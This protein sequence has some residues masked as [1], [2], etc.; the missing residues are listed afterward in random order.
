LVSSPSI[1]ISL[2][3][4]GDFEKHTKGIGSKILR[5]MGYDGQGLGKRSQGIISP[6]VATQR[7]K[8]EGLGFDGISGKSHD[9]E[10]HF[11]EG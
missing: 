1:E 3:N 5:K 11:C 6:I 8:H 2:E 9:H 4:I 10:D 7:A